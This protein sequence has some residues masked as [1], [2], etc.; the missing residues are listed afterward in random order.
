MET[1]LTEED[2]SASRNSIHNDKEHDSFPTERPVD[3]EVRRKR[4]STLLEVSLAVPD[5]A[6]RY[7]SNASRVHRSHFGQLTNLS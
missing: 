1:K 7:P 3:L 4:L 2:T 5:V 6:R